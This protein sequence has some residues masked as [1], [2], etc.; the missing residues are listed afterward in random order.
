MKGYD[1]ETSA[2]ERERD[3]KR[4]KQRIYTNEASAIEEFSFFNLRIL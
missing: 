2:R 1:I 3:N 4:K